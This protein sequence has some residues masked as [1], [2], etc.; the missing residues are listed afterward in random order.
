MASTPSLNAASRSV[1]RDARPRGP[2]MTNTLPGD[3]PSRTHPQR[4]RRAQLQSVADR[5]IDPYQGGVSDSSAVAEARRI[6]P[7]PPIKA[8]RQGATPS[9]S[10]SR[11]N[12]GTS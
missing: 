10:V 5:A 2:D 6:V 12:S 1:L 4:A 9:I 7:A 8:R 3:G 11:E